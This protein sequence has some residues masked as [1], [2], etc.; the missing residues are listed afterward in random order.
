MATH[1]MAQLRAR[2][3][4][5]TAELSLLLLPLVWSST[6]NQSREDNFTDFTL[7]NQCKLGADYPRKGIKDCKVGLT[8]D[9]PTGIHQHWA[10]PRCSL[11]PPHGHR[12]LTGRVQSW[13]CRPP[14]QQAPWAS[15]RVWE[16][17]GRLSLKPR[18]PPCFSCFGGKLLLKRFPCPAYLYRRQIKVR[19]LSCRY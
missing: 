6:G 7:K 16:D 8:Q 4:L 11:P 12:Q 18:A 9:W 15:A 17:C 19:C 5:G 14:G 13:G 1:H 10:Q 2:V 3:L